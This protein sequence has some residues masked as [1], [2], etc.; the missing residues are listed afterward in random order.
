MQATPWGSACPAIANIGNIRGNCP[1]V[2][3]QIEDIID[4]GLTL[5]K[6]LGAI[7]AAG[8]ASVR[9]VTLL[10]KAARRKVELKP[11]FAG[12]DCPDEFVVGYGLDFDEK[13]R[14]LPY[15]GVLHPR[16]YGGEH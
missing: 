1:A 8:P 11:D 6:L 16:C 13:Y 15:V 2:E 4:T 14:G 9:T 10:D 7:K 5:T 3:L 12:F